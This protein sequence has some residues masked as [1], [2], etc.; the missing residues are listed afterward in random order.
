MSRACVTGLIMLVLGHYPSLRAQEPAPGDELSQHLATL[1]AQVEDTSLA[2]GQREALIQE[3]AGALDRAARGAAA[4]DQRHERWARAVG[5]LDE[6]NS[7]NPGHP[8]TREFQLQAAVYR[9]AQGQGWREAGEL[10]PGDSR[11]PRE[12]AAAL[13]DAIVRLRAISVEDFE[14]VLGDNV[15]FRL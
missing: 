5:L 13:D 8:K 4:A 6:F 12:A 3:M 2:I 7:Q 9:W 15:R 10:N 1:K 14:K 11:A